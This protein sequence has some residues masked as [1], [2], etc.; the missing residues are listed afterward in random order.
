M[1]NPLVG[2]GRFVKQDCHVVLDTPTAQVIDKKTGKVLLSADFEPWSA[3]WN[4]CPKKQ[5]P[6]LPGPTQNRCTRQHIDAPTK[7]IFSQQAN[8]AHRIQTKGELA[9]FHDDSDGWPVK[10][11]WIEAIN[12]GSCAS[13]PS[14]TAAMV[15]KYCK[16]SESM[17]QV[18]MRAR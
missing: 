4:A 10:T 1:P 6:I 13:W 18:L 12:R 7:A 15:H 3:T 9:T 11:I 8:D 5:Q 16:R 17:V 14:L 2:C